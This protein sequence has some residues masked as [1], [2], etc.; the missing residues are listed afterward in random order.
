MPCLCPIA[1]ILRALHSRLVLSP[2]YK[3]MHVY[4]LYVYTQ[5]TN[6]ASRFYAVLYLFYSVHVCNAQ[7]TTNMYISR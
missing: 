5:S 2:T 4:M 6:A 1:G 7:C 3:Y